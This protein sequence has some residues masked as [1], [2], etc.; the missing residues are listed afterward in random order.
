MA[1]TLKKLILFSFILLITCGVL[2]F[3]YFNSQIK[4][5]DP[6]NIVEKK[7]V[8][9]KG[10][11]TNDIANLLNENKL[12]SSKLIFKILAKKEGKDGKLKA[13]KYSLNSGMSMTEILYKIA[14]GDTDK[15][16][17][18]FTI[19]EGYE[20]KEIADRLAN[21]G[22]VNRK[23]FLDLTSKVSNF[24]NEYEFLKKIPQNI[25]LEGYLFPDTY[26]VFKDS[27]EEEIIKKMLDRFDEVYQTLIKK[28]IKKSTL[29]LHEIITL[30]SIIEREGK[31]DSERKLISAVFYNRLNKGWYLQSCATVQYVLGERK[32]NLTYDDLKIDSKYNTYLYNGLPPGPIASPGSM[33]IEAALKPAEVD[34]LF[35]V[36]NG[37][38]SHTFTKSLKEHINAKNKK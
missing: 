22:L 8:I 38:G 13:G 28:E 19:P 3:S 10:S 29:S 5:V 37:D 30:A 25:S 34:Y 32:Q 31:L 1:K 26:E 27:K 23:V 6:Y 4:P 20:L 9:P 33:S 18:T 14:K 12:I 16:T 2:G 21:L 7:I 24:S 35:F 17:V 36:S 15:E 11:T